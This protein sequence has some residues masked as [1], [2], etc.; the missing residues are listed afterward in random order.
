MNYDVVPLSKIREFNN[1]TG[2]SQIELHLR[3]LR[4]FTSEG[5]DK[6]KAALKHVATEGFPYFIEM[7]S[8][9]HDENKIYIENQMNQMLHAMLNQNF[10]RDA[11]TDGAV[12]PLIDESFRCKDVPNFQEIIEFVCWGLPSERQYFSNIQTMNM[13][14]MIK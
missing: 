7:L 10:A 8:R 6:L 4:G 13:K 12:S 1:S 9:G 3:A 14:L 5:K 2:N 11:I